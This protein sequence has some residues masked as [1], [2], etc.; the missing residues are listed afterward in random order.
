MSLFAWLGGGGPTAAEVRAEI[1][2]LGVRH[3]GR[4]LDGALAELGDPNLPMGR[5]ALLRGCVAKLQA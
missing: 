3:L 5:V 4:P 2:K 1:W